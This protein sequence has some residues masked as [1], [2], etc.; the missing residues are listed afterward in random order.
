ME[1]FAS[2]RLKLRMWGVSVDMG[3]DGLWEG[4]LGGLRLWKC[5]EVR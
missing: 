3:S 5:V 4:R 2:L 1:N